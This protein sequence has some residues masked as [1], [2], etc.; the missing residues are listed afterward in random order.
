MMTIKLLQKSTKHFSS[1]IVKME[2]D[3][4]KYILFDSLKWKFTEKHWGRMNQ[5]LQ[6]YL[7]TLLSAFRN[8]YIC[9]SALFNMIENFKSNLDKGD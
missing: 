6:L 8:G 5:L 7:S 3:M 2:N 9:Q 1:N 4:K